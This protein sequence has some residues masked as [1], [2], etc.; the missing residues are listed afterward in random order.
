MRKRKKI[1]ATNFPQGTKALLERS[2]KIDLTVKLTGGSYNPKFTY[3]SQARDLGQRQPTEIVSVHTQSSKGK[4]FSST[5][6]K[7]SNNVNSPCVTGGIVRF[8]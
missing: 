8:K 6:K 4:R 5:V 2:S 7:K 3:F 1:V